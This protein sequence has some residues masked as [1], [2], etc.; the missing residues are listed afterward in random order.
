[1]LKHLWP[2]WTVFL[3]AILFFG[4][5]YGSLAQTQS[6]SPDAVER[7]RKQFEQACGFCHGPDATGARGPD[8]VTYELDGR[9]YLIMAVQDILYAFALPEG[10]VRARGTP[11]Q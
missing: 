6:T 4:G 9:Q 3:P 10:A 7:G 1:M 5:V 8:L 2:E 11:A